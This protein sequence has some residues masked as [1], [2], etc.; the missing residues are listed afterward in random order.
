MGLPTPLSTKSATRPIWC[1]HVV[2]LVPHGFDF[3]LDGVANPLKRQI[4]IMGAPNQI[5]CAANRRRG[6][7]GAGW[8]WLPL[9]ART[10]TTFGVDFKVYFWGEHQIGDAADLQQTVRL[11]NLRGCTKSA[12]RPIC[13]KPYVYIYIFL[14]CT[15]SAT[16]PICSKPYVCIYFG[17]L[18]LLQPK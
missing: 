12:T 1:P 5:C 9:R 18:P 2:D 8:G 7:F 3:V 11:Y 4:N 10:N 6:R 14:G 17:G 13:S 16:R 15:K